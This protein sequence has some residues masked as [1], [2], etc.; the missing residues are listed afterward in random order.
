MIRRLCIVFYT[1][2][3][4]PLMAQTE[5]DWQAPEHGEH[6]L[7]GQLWHTETE[8]FESLP[9]YLN[10]LPDGSW[11]LLGERHDNPDHH[12]LQ[13]WILKQ[14]AETGR[15]GT[16]ALEMAQAEQQT[17]LDEWSGRG[18]EVTAEQL[19][20]SPG[21]PWERY[22]SQVRLA[23]NQA[24]RVVGADLPRSAQM[25]AYR[26]G[27]A[28]GQL[29]DAHSRYMMELIYSSHCGHLPRANL[30][31]MLQVQLGRDQHMAA[32]MIETADPHKVNVLIAGAM[33]VRKDLGIPRWLSTAHTSLIMTPLD[34]ATDAIDY[35]DKV[36][37]HFPNGE[38]S[39][40]LLLFT[41]AMPEQDHCAAFQ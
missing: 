27:A 24:S 13:T 22:E 18:D 19:N 41:P 17:Q 5:I 25:Q 40:D 37:P 12:Q 11:L 4:W 3:A 20:W 21:W 32:R 10:Q 14:L 8:R 33:H 2:L 29:D 16:V 31:Q 39:S 30:V 26:L 28:E 6:P 35:R 7:A 38:L 9:T 1:L 36:Y 34:Q 23:L 15:L